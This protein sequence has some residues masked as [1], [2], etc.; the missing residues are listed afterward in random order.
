MITFQ[1]LH[2]QLASVVTDVVPDGVA[3]S[4]SAESAGVEWLVA[5]G[6]G[7]GAVVAVSDPAAPV[8]QPVTYTTRIGSVV[9][10]RPGLRAHRDDYQIDTVLTSE[11]GRVSV[12]VLWE[13]SAAMTV[14]PRASYAFPL[15]SR[16]AVQHRPVAPSAPSWA[17]EFRVDL[18]QVADTRLIL[19]SGRF[20]ALH[21]HERCAVGCSIPRAMLVGIDGAI[22]EASWTDGRTYS[23]KLQQLE[24]SNTGLPVTAWGDRGKRVWSS[25]T[26]FAG[27]RQKIA[28]A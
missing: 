27:M 2:T 6:V 24:V 13:G 14:D 11:D 12:P 21:V 3:F 5:E 17:F 19:E 25:T 16:F 20:W 26:T 15:A 4:V 18:D 22:S 10:S 9:K 8:D 28:G 23:V 1:A 7:V